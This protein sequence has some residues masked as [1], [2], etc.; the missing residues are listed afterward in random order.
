MCKKGVIWITP[1][2]NLVH[3]WSILGI[4]YTEL[5]R[6]PFNSEKEQNLRKALIHRNLSDFEVWYIRIL[7]RYRSLD[8]VETRW[9]S[10]ALSC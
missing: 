5:G 3:F 8:I 9:K 1:P 7:S 10:V 4:E 2:F 6:I